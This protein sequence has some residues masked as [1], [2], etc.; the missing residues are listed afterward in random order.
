MTNCSSGSK[1][2]R[3]IEVKDNQDLETGKISNETVQIKN[4]ISSLEQTI[5]SPSKTEIFSIFLLFVTIGLSLKS[6]KFQKQTGVRES[7]EQL[8]EVIGGNWKMKPILHSYNTH[9]GYLGTSQ[10]DI[11]FYQMH[12]EKIAQAGRFQRAEHN[13]RCSEEEF[14]DISGVISAEIEDNYLRITCNSIDAIKCRNTAEKAMR[15]VIESN[16]S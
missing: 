6:L 12:H 11:K 13:I 4:H 5:S 3:E 2:L 7:I 9:F 14:E 1:F 10:I 16:S 15:M 8:N